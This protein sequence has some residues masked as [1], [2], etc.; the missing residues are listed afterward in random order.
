MTK[1]HNWNLELDLLVVGSGNGA[2]T[3]AIS[4]SLMGLKDIVVIEKSDAFGGTSGMSGGGIWVPGNHYAKAEGQQDSFEDARRYL[5]QVIP[6][7]MVPQEMI[8]T[9]LRTAPEMVSFLHDNTQ[10]RYQSLEKYPD[11][12]TNL[13][14]SREGHRSLEPEPINRDVLGELMHKLVV[15]GPM[16]IANR[17]AITQ[18]EG[19]ILVGKLKG[20]VGIFI[21]LV[22]SY[23]LD[24]KW[25]KENKFSRRATAGAAGI[26]RLWLSMRDRNIPL[27]RNTALTKLIKEGDRIIGA[28]ITFSEDATL[29]GQSFQKGQTIA[30]KCNNGVLLAAGGFEQNQEMREQYLPKPTSTEWSA[31]CVTNTGDAI[32]LG[33]DIGAQTRLMNQAWWCTTLCVPKLPYPFLSIVTKSLPGCI[34]VNQLGKRFS[35][36]S[37]NYMAFQLEAFEKHSTDNPSFPMYMIFDHG[38]KRNYAVFPIMGPKR[39]LPERLFSEKFLAIENSLEALAEKMDIDAEGLKETIASFNHH[40]KNGEDPE[41]DRGK[42]AYD[43]YYGDPKV[44]PNPCLAPIAKPPF[45]AMRM[46]PGD[47]GTQGGLV[48]NTH[49]QVLSDDDTP[50]AGLYACGNCS[51]AILPTYPGP[52]STLGPAMTFA[53]L[54]AKHMTSEQN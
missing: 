49:G 30:V 53:Y 43:R 41:F 11:Y 54:A 52:G 42:S 36:E 39:F 3:G 44:S 1:T 28:E 26:I 38:F 8:D 29:K 20:Y 17:I 35:N 33:Q 9:Y 14:G 6:E 31:G 21:K 15:G 12:Y 23:F 13:E 40:A 25:R 27:Q 24:A 5:E 46:E 4:A 37:Q 7:G 18:V 19:Q 32:R 16:F 34:T 48:T 10:V 45:Y 22:L 50:I 51:A 47:F 2:M